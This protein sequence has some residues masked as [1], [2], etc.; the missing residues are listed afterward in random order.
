MPC[1]GADW[2]LGFTRELCVSSPCSET[3]AIVAY[4][5]RLVLKAKLLSESGV[6]GVGLE[7]HGWPFFTD[8]RKCT[9]RLQGGL[10]V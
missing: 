4:A 5:P 6:D 10:E 2:G 7:P 8:N 3:L 9:A 1:L